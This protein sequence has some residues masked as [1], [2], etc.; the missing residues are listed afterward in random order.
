MKKLEIMT[1]EEKIEALNLLQIYVESAVESEQETPADFKL[2]T[3]HRI[4]LVL[5]NLK[6]IFGLTDIA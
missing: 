3:Q 2:E 1:H 6:E 5:V 4:N